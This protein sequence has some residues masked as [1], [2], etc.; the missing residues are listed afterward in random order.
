[1]NAVLSTLS[2]TRYLDLV[3]V[4]NACLTYFLVVLL[5]NVELQEKELLPDFVSEKL[6]LDSIPH[7]CDAVL[8]VSEPLIVLQ[9]VD[10]AVT[11]VG[12]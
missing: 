12:Q 4:V 2:Q 9:K 3:T 6:I 10:F 11:T 7:Y 1:M 5:V 8:F